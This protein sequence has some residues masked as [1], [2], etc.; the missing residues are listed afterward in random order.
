MLDQRRNV[1]GPSRSQSS[2]VSS[3][4]RGADVVTGRP[5]AKAFGKKCGPS[6]RLFLECKQSHPK[7]A[8]HLQE[9]I[10]CALRYFCEK[11]DLKWLSLL[12]SAGGDPRSRGSSLEKDYTN[13]PDYYTSG[14]GRPA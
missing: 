9:Q 3:L 7:L 2:S 13:E 14:F 5:L 10:D 11:G 12:M 4:T 1:A 8:V 6:L